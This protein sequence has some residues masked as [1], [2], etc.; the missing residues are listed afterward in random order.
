MNVELSTDQVALIREAMTSMKFAEA[1]YETARAKLDAVLAR[2][3][4]AAGH[5][6]EEGSL[7]LKTGIVTLPDPAVAPACPMPKASP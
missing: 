1:Q 7:D 6:I 2:I 5:N 3:S 4:L